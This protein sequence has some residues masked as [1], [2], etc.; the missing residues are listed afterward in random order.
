MTVEEKR[1]SC[2]NY[3]KQ[4]CEKLKE[5][6]V[7]MASCNKDVSRYLVPK[8][9]EDQVTYYGKPRDSYRISDH[10]NWKT[11]IK[12]CS[13]PHYVQCYNKSIRMMHRRKAP[14]LASKGV[15][16]WCVAYY[17]EDDAYHT[18]HG[19]EYLGNHKRNW[20]WKEGCVEDI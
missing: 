3:W 13:D 19:A 4:L 7:E 20:S 17:G 11:S 6:H 16:A 2:E 14:E 10:W 12:K 18:V 8:G 5:T 1:E 15:V 9:T